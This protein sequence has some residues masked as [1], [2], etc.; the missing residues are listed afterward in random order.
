ML[1]YYFDQVFLKKKNTQKKNTH[2]QKKNKKIKK[3]VHKQVS[4]KS[5]NYTKFTK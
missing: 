5:K 1:P 4:S 2:T 3:T